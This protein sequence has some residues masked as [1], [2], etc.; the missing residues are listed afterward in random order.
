MFAA[1]AEHIRPD[2]VYFV[3][4]DPNVTRLPEWLAEFVAP[5]D[6]ETPS[7]SEKTGAPGLHQ[8]S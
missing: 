2:F 6:G 7:P 1:V 3:F 5:Q 4:D 8:Q